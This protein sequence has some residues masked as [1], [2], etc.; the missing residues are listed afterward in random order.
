[1]DTI[2]FE[3]HYKIMCKFLD[4]FIFACRISFKNNTQYKCQCLLPFCFCRSHI[5]HLFEN[6]RH[7]SHL[8]TL[9]REM[10]FR[11]EMVSFYVIF[12]ES[13]NFK[14]FI[15]E[16]FKDVPKQK[17]PL[18]QPTAST[19]DTAVYLLYTPSH[20]GNLRRHIISSVN[21]FICVSKE[22]NFL[23]PTVL[24]THLKMMN[25]DFLISINQCLNDQLAFFFLQLVCWQA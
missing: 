21:T 1:M 5:T 9:E 4:T 16:I 24:L 7:F 3:F 13:K 14:L 8:S 20:I 15:M 18:S 23:L 6:D 17:A 2:I 10:A 12:Q 25:S 19:G 11:T 22:R